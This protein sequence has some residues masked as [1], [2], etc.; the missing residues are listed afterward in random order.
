M[1]GWGAFILVMLLVLVAAPVQAQGEAGVKG[2]AV[3]GRVVTG[4]GG[5][6]A[7][8]A[9]GCVSTL[10]PG[11][12]DAALLSPHRQW[13]C[14]RD[15]GKV[16]SAERV[17]IRFSL[18]HAVGAEFFGT[19]PTLFESLTLAVVSKGRI[20]ARE[21]YPAQ[22]LVA[23]LNGRLVLVAIP[24]AA[25][26]AP[27]EEILA[28]FE[29]PSSWALIAD[30]R[31]F[32]DD[33][34]LGFHAKVGILITAVI[35]GMLLMPLAFNVAYYRVLKESFVLWHLA[36]TIA[37]LI[38]CLLTSGI[39]SHF[40]AIPVPVFWRLIDIS[41]AMAVASAAG[42]CA[43]FIEPDK[44]SAR[45]RSALYVVG[46]QVL[47][48]GCVDIFMPDAFGSWQ[49]AAY[50]L[51][52]LPALLLF[53]IVMVQAIRRGS[54]SVRYQIIGWTPFVFVGATRIVTMIFP[55]LRPDEAMNLFYFAMVFESV[56]TSLGV[57]DRF[58]VIKKERDLAMQKAE[59]FETLSHRDDL[60]GLYN[61]RALE[62]IFDQP[63]NAPFTG[64]ALFDLDNF[65]RVNDTHGHATGDA[66]L[67]TVAG[68]LAGHDDSVALRLGGEEF[69]LLLRGDQVQ[70]RV[71]RLREAVPVR[72]AREVTSLELLVT[73][74][75]GLVEADAAGFAGL[76][77]A[78]LYQAA[79]D[80]LYEAKHNG[81]NLLAAVKGLPP[82]AE[83]PS[84]RG[85]RGVTLLKA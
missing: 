46:A 64:F 42:F 33:P 31:L 47:A 25:N 52:Y 39:L 79:D 81:R 19:K 72:I 6:T 62:G 71:E 75:A 4:S 49:N 59:S 40:I 45:L 51:G 65:K 11:E 55:G 23:S 16:L 69:L 35:C 10:A 83:Q 41:F 12:T 32:A 37:L 15:D 9:A 54:R 43:A 44:I 84:G 61:R 34:T 28:I 73:A 29:R 82:R 80:L 67:R 2:H 8:V 76:D 18:D 21:R 17:A 26:G 38:Q 60:T 66:V 74:S 50:Y 77:F 57:A 24:K 78:T 70:Q 63:S 7:P 36:L 27:A 5:A 3:T 68:V 14:H 48:L 58:L 20:V 53:V 56:A 85:W 13:Q 1:R 30:A 22:D